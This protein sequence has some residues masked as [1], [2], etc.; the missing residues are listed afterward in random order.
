[1]GAADCAAEMKKANAELK[2]IA[3]DVKKTIKTGF[4]EVK[5]GVSDVAEF[6]RIIRAHQV[7]EQRRRENCCACRF[8][9]HWAPFTPLPFPFKRRNQGPS[10]AL[11]HDP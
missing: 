4:G 2:A 11:P 10:D 3:A 5:R 7:R 1:M 9:L 8:H 6:T